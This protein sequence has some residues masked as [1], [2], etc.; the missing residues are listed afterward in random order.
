MVQT[1]TNIDYVHTSFQYPVLTK[2]L[3]TPTYALLKHI[4]DEMKANATNVQ[5]NLG[6][7]KYGH[8]GLVLTPAEYATVSTT[9]YVRPV[10]PGANAAPAATQWESQVNRDK[11]QEQI[12]CSGRLMVSKQLS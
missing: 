5:C 4:K 8:L 12:A 2:V 3:D 7:G 10:H 6:G 1:N 11:H 9:P